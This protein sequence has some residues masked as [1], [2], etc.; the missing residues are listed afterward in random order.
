MDQDC[1]EQI[2]SEDYADL[3][4][5]YI[6][7]NS[8]V[9]SGYCYSIISNNDAVIHMPV[10]NLP[11]NYIQLYGYGVNPS[12]Y[13]LMDIPSIEASGV[14]TLRSLPATN[15]R[16]Q[17]VLVGIVDTGIDYTHDAFLHADN[18]SR[19]ISIWDQTIQEGDPPE[20]FNFGTE[21]VQTEINEALQMPNPDAF[22]PTTDNIGHGTFLAG[23]A[24]G[25][26]IESES[27]SGVAPDS[28]LVVV[29]L[30]EAKL[31]LKEFFRIPADATAYQ[32]N[33]IMLAVSYL[34]Q[35]ASRLQRPISICIG[36]GTSQGAHDEM[37][38]F[39]SYLNFA[40]NIAGVAVSIAAGNE[41]NRG[42][43]YYGV[44][45]NNIE[46]DTVELRVGPNEYGFSMELWGNAPN[47]FS[48]DI[49]SPTGEYIPRIPARINE[50]RE[51][52]FIFEETVINI[53]YF[54]IESQTGDQLILVRFLSPTEGIWRFRVYATGDLELSY[55]VWL[56]ISEFM[57][58]NTFFAEPTPTTTVTS[59]GNSITPMTVTA[60]NIANN[61]LYI[62]AGRGFSRTGI[63]VPDFA[64]PGV[65]LIG[66][67]PN[68]SYTVMSGTS[69]ATAHNTGIA[70]LLLEWGVTLGNLPSLSTVEIKNLL[71]RG[72]VRDPN[73][74]YPNPNWGFGII[75]LY[76]TFINIRGDIL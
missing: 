8:I 47:T 2:M 74:I 72:A 10:E 65:N 51:I 19:I 68:N 37:G 50:S 7:I 46:Y 18:T 1:R 71:I 41:S 54:L 21:Y 4:V 39:T 60:Y 62:N 33:D 76:N 11:N 55:H 44:I 69:I 38:T 36:V 66:P 45:G 58:G 9:E 34:L 48:I 64:A 67:T 30:K 49:L 25:N 63:V 52:R 27:F 57:S 24:A 29:K 59:P 75:N 28:E 15:L 43:H 16:G 23:I 40:S 6:N 5:R 70:A 35:V 14:Y 20:G 32:E 56:P 73:N 13:G 31:Y 12:C 3:L 26:T 61:S 42:H 22:V 17:G 53:D